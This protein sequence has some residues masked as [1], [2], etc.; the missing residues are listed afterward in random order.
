MYVMVFIIVMATGMVNFID[1][2]SKLDLRNAPGSRDKSQ[3]A[4]M[5]CYVYG[6]IAAIDLIAANVN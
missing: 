3:P 2:V 1:A 4:L 5:A 6:G